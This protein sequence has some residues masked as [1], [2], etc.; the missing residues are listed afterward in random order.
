MTLRRHSRWQRLC[1]NFCLVDNFIKYHISCSFICTESTNVIYLLVLL[2]STA[3]IVFAVLIFCAY[4]VQYTV[5]LTFTEN[6]QAARNNS[7]AI[8]PVEPLKAFISKIKV[9][10]ILWPVV[11]CVDCG[12]IFSRR[13]THGLCLLL[14]YEFCRMSHLN[15]KQIWQILY[16]IYFYWLSVCAWLFSRSVDQPLPMLIGQCVNVVVGSCR[17]VPVCFVP[18]ETVQHCL[19]WYHGRDFQWLR[20]TLA[21]SGAIVS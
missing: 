3:F 16:R 17:S 18:D 7:S 12:E 5:S 4:I 14:K 10:V 2:Y 6:T 21:D 9:I 20:C 15:T 19:Y 13:W 8:L 11:W 1:V